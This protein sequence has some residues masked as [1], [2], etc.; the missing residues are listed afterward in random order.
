[1]FGNAYENIGLF[2]TSASVVDA[3]GIDE[4]DTF[5]INAGLD[6]VDS[7][8]TGLETLADVLLLLRDEVDE[9]FAIT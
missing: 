3:R 8:G 1:M 6:D 5:P 4:H 9:L 7:S 2:H